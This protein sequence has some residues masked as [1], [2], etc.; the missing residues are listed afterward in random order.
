MSS[1]FCH[2]QA[3]GDWT[4]IQMMLRK[5]RKHSISEL[6]NDSPFSSLGLDLM[7]LIVPESSVFSASL[8][9]LQLN[10][11]LALEEVGLCQG[12]CISTCLKWEM[13]VQPNKLNSASVEMKKKRKRN[14]TNWRTFQDAWHIAGYLA[15][16]GLSLFFWK[17]QSC[18]ALNHL[19]YWLIMMIYWM[20]ISVHSE[21]K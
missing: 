7:V 9:S 8:L 11:R 17:E 18:F 13:T 21:L 14:S 16:G 4:V 1:D 19:F 2:W 5:S 6:Q 20:V 15:K 12:E 3:E 10:W